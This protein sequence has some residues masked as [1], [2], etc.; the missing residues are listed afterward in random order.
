MVRIGDDKC[1][2]YQPDEV[3][4][5]LHECGH[6]PGGVADHR[7][8]VIVTNEVESDTANVAGDRV[9]SNY[10]EHPGRGRKYSCNEKLVIKCRGFLFCFV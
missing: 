5:S 4:P 9:C 2:V 1:A 7:G 8:V 3:R 6:T 10:A